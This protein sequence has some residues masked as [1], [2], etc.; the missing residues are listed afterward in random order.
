MARRAIGDRAWRAGRFPD[1]LGRAQFDVAAVLTLEPERST[2]FFNIAPRLAMNIADVQS[3]GLIQTG[4]RVWY[5]LYAAGSPAQVKALE[6]AVKLER[7]QRIDTLD[8]GRPEVRGAVDRAQR[9]LGLTA[10]LAAILAGVAVALGTRRFVERHLDGCA[11]MRCL[12]ATQ[13]QLLRLYALEFVSL[14]LGACALGCVLGYIA[15]EAIG[16]AVAEVVRAELPPPRVLPAV[17]GFLVGLVLLLGFALPPLV[18]LKNVPAVRVLRRESGTPKGGTLA[19][20]AAGL[21]SLGA[22]LIWQAGDLKLGLYVGRLCRG[23]GGVLPDCMGVAQSRDEPARHLR[24]PYF[25]VA[26][27]AREPAASRAATRCRSRAS[28]SV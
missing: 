26:L 21:V 8:T 16:M 11:V 20:Y 10:L 23:G 12:G 9:F 25:N 27:R 28:R 22:L 24:R 19:A 1:Q 7:G 3:T 15:Q 14:G 2:S 13:S 5:Y 6:R 17:Q 4:S 18:Q